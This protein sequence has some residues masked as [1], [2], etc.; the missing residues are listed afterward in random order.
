M[1]KRVT[2][3][4]FL[5]IVT[6]SF[7]LVGQ[8]SACRGPFAED[9][10]YPSCH[11]PEPDDN[12]LVILVTIIGGF[13]SFPSASVH[14]GEPTKATDFIT[15]DIAP[16]EDRHYLIL[17]SRDQTIWNIEGDIDS[18]SRVVV[19]GATRL[20]PWAAGVIGIPKNRITFTSPNL[21]AMDTVLETSCTRY[22][23]SCTAM[24]WFGQLRRTDKVFFH[25]PP[26]QQ[27]MQFDAHIVVSGREDIWGQSDWPVSS[28][29]AYPEEETVVVNPAAV[30]APRGAVPYDQ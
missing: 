12:E 4:V 23:Y 29:T 10:H 27:Q 2:A 1:L 14:V 5:N 15:I 19:L 20:G 30:V 24:Q 25:P 16:N 28:R 22:R 11:I 18:V 17:E 9:H 26:K 6:V 3:F 13:P 7:L 21:K 8:A